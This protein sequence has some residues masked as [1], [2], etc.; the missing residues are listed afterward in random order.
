MPFLQ[1]ENESEWIKP[2]GDVVGDAEPFGS[3]EQRV[4]REAFEL[5]DAERH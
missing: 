1:A 3:L 2:W 4:G 5:Q